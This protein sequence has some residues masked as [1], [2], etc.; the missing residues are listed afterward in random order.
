MM[1]YRVV[2]LS[3]MDGETLFRMALVLQH[4]G[5]FGESNS[6]EA[7]ADDINCTCKLDFP[8]VPNFQIVLEYKAG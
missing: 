4:L 8:R 1:R 7:V 2:Y 6:P 3:C 5:T